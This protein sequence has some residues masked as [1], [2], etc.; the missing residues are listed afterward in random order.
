M[1]PCTYIRLTL[2]VAPGD[3]IRFR[4][5]EFTDINGLAPI[6]GLIS[7]QAL[8]FRDLDF[9]ADRLGQLWL[10]EENVASPHISMLDHGPT[11]ARG[12]IVDSG[13]LACNIDAYLGVTPEPELSRR[14]FYVLA[15]AFAKLSEDGSLPP[16][17]EF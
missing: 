11:Q 8:C 2:G 4:S 15:N 12:A 14:V 10:S 1:A 6:H 17:A 13:A 7:G 16:E 3:R 9:V 5:L